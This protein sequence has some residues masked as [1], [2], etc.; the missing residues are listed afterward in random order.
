MSRSILGPKVRLVLGNALLEDRDLGVTR[1]DRSRYTVDAVRLV[2][3]GVPPPEGSADLTSWEVF[4]GYLVLDALIGN[5]DR[6]EENWAVVETE[7]TRRLAPS[8]DHASSLGFLLSD[9]QRQERLVSRDRN[10]TPEGWADRARTKFAASPHPVEV[11]LGIRQSGDSEIVDR[12]LLVEGGVD[13]LVAPIWRIPEHR[14][15]VT[16]KNF[17]ERVLRRNWERL[18]TRSR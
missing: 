15:S 12:W 7:E 11:V 16:S 18:T 9:S 17:A 6:H 8:F 2:L 1:G 10:F 13:E 14:M 5:T 3:E 4:V